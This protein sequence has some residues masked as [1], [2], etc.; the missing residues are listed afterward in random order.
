MLNGRTVLVTRPAHLAG[1]LVNDI[2]KQGGCSVLLP[3]VEIE[4]LVDANELGPIFRGDVFYDLGIFSSKNAIQVVA[5]WCHQEN[6]HWPARMACATV[7]AKTAE[8]AKKMFGLDTVICPKVNS[9]ARELLKMKHLTHVFEQSIVIFDG[10]NGAQILQEHLEGSC[11]KLTSYVVYRRILPK[12]DT[13]PVKE[14]LNGRGVDYVVV[15]SV[16]GA[17]NLFKLLDQESTERVADS[18]FVAYSAR[19][20]EYLESRGIAR[21][22]IAEQASDSAVLKEILVHSKGQSHG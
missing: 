10:E 16:A 8:M 14:A 9:G 18:C 17:S 13:G 21:I 1:P 4:N 15:T 12:A 7:G 2:E 20:G 6:L 5:Q 22:R 19:I 11:K 3:T